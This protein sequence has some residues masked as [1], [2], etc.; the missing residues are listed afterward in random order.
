MSRILRYRKTLSVPIAAAEMPG[1]TIRPF[2]TTADADAWLQLHAEVFGRGS[3][4]NGRRWLADDF[5]REFTAKPWWMPTCMWF[6]ELAEATADGDGKIVGTATLGRRGVPLRDEATLAWLMVRP[7]HRCRGIG[8]ALI[9]TVERT[10]W[11][12]GARELSLETHVAW[13]D[14]RRLYQQCGYRSTVVS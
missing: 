4:S 9:G 13:H 5:A 1:V 2:I 3:T 12:D 14:A 6:A 7:D 8:R 11:N 10:A